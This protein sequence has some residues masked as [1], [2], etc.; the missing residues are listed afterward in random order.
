[1]RDIR[2]RSETKRSAYNVHHKVCDILITLVTYFFNK[3]TGCVRKKWGWKKHITSET[4][5][6]VVNLT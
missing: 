3:K 2:V 6:L 4:G 5:I 1:M